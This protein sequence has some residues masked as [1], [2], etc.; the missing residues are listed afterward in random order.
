MNIPIFRH[1]GAPAEYPGIQS[2][3][4]LPSNLLPEFLTYNGGA[5]LLRYNA[6]ENYGSCDFID[7]M[8]K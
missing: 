6:Q 7:A 4:F 8:L 3:T 5:R 2:L 1:T